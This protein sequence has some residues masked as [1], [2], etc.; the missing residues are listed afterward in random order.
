MDM[1][2]GE[3]LSARVIRGETEAPVAMSPASLMKHHVTKHILANQANLMDGV[4][5]EMINIEN[6]SLGS[7][8]KR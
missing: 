5:H 8:R 2:F 4:A 1:D 6:T 7:E 3:T